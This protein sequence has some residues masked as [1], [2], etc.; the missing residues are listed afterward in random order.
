MLPTITSMSISTV[1]VLLVRKSL[2]DKMVEWKGSGLSNKSDVGETLYSASSSHD[3]QHLAGKLFT[4]SK[5]HFLM[6]KI[7][8]VIIISQTFS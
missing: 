8:M 5:L 2:K 3:L 7:K 1:S 6:C 4:A